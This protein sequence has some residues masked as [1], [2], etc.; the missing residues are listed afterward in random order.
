M[1]AVRHRVLNLRGAGLGSQRHPAALSLPLI[2]A[3][4]DPDPGSHKGDRCAD[5]RCDHNHRDKNGR[6]GMPCVHRR[7]SSEPGQEQAEEMSHS[8][9]LPR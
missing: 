1:K 2:L 8:C 7:D 5:P 4:A 3:R 9:G 6:L